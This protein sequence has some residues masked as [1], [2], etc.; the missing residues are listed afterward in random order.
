MKGRN[1]QLI[2]PVQVCY[3]DLQVNTEVFSYEYEKMILLKEIAELMG[4]DREAVYKRH[5][6]ALVKLKE[7]LEAGNEK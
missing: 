3:A 2:E 1:T 5:Q 7:I 4:M 6:R